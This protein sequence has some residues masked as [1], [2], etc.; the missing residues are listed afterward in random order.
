MKKLLTIILTLCMCLSL[1]MAL[2]AC[3]LG[4]EEPEHTHTYENVWSYDDTYHWYACG[5]E[6]CSSTSQKAEHNI[7]SDTCSI[8]GYEQTDPTPPP[9]QSANK[10]TEEEFYAAFAFEDVVSVTIQSESNTNI[11][12]GVQQGVHYA[13][14]FLDGNK[15]KI[16]S[17]DITTY[18]EFYDTYVYIYALDATDNTWVRSTV[19]PENAAGL[20]TLA[21]LEEMLDGADFSD[22]S[23][24]DGYYIGSQIFEEGTAYEYVVNFKFQFENGKLISARGEYEVEGFDC[25]DYMTFT[26]YNSTTVNVPTEYRENEDEPTPPA[27]SSWASYFE[28][29]NV[30]ATKISSTYYA[31]YDMTLTETES[32]KVDGSEWLWETTDYWYG[33]TSHS[34]FVVYFDGLNAYVNGVVDN[35]FDSQSEM[36]FFDLDFSMYESSFDEATSGVYTAN[37]INMY[38]VYSYE[39]VR[40]T[41]VDENISTISYEVSLTV[42]GATYTTQVSCSFSDWNETVVDGEQYTK[43]SVWAS[44]FDFDNVTINETMQYI[45]G[46]TT[47]YGL[48]SEWKVD[49]DAWVCNR[50]MEKVDGIVTR[51]NEVY[52]NGINYYLNGEPVGEEDAYAYH[53]MTGSILGELVGSERLFQVT[54]QGTKTIYTAT[55]IMVFD[56]VMYTDVELVVENG[57]IVKITYVRDN[58]ASFEGQHYAGTFTLEF[59][60]Y[61]VTIVEGS[62]E[63][64]HTCS[65]TEEIPLPKFMKSD[66]TCYDKA[67]YYLSCECGEYREDTFEFGEAL[68]CDWGDWVSSGA[69][70]HA[71]I[72]SRDF[73]HTETEYCSGGTASC[74]RLAICDFCKVGYGEL[75][76]HVYLELKNNENEHWFECSCGAKDKIKI[77]VPSDVATESSDQIC[78][79]CNRVLV[80]ALGHVHALHLEKVEY[81]ES[82][83]IEAGNIEYYICSCNKMFEDEM[84]II[85]I[86]DENDVVLE[87]KAHSYNISK[88]D[89]TQHWYQCVCGDIIGKEK[90]K[91][92]TATCVLKAECS[93]CGEKYGELLSHNFVELKKGED[94]HWYECVCGEKS[95]AEFHKGGSAS[96]TKLAEC[97]ICF[98]SYGELL[99]HYFD[100]IKYNENEHWYE[101]ICGKKNEQE[102][103][104]GGVATCTEFAV[105]SVCEIEYGE[106]SEHKGGSATCKTKA[107]CVECEMEYGEFGE[108]EFNQEIIEEEYRLSDAT[109]THAAWYFYA[110]LCGEKGDEFFVY[111]EALG[112]DYI[113]LRFDSSQHWYECRCGLRTGTEKHKG[114]SVDC[115][116]LPICSVC[117]QQ[118]GSLISHSWNNGCCTTCGTE[119]YSE[120]L[121]FTLNDD[122]KSYSVTGVTSTSGSGIGGDVIILES[123]VIV[124]TPDLPIV[125]GNVFVSAVIPSIYKGLPVTRIEENAFEGCGNLVNVSIGNNVVEIG[126]YAFW[127]CSKLETINIPNGILTIGSQAFSG[128]D[129]LMYNEID[130]LYYLGNISN[131]CVYLIKVAN[132]IMTSVNVDERCKLIRGG[133]LSG[134]NI[135]DLRLP[136]VGESVTGS[137]KTH[138]G[139]IFGATTYDYNSTKI[140]A[141]L[142]TV[143]VL[144]NRIGD[145]AFYNASD[146]TTVVLSTD[147]DS[148]G[149]YSF[150]GCCSLEEIYLGD[151][152]SSVGAYAFKNCLKLSTIAVP[153]TVEIIGYAAFEGC[154]SLTYIKLP[155][156]GGKESDSSNNHFGYIFGAHQFL[157][158]VNYV[159]DSLM[160]ISIDRGMISAQAFNGCANLKTVEIGPDVSEIGLNAFSGCSGISE[161]YVEDLTRWCSIVGLE[162]LM[163]QGQAKN[164]FVKDILLVNLILPYDVLEIQPFAFANCKSIESVDLGSRVETIWYSVFKGSNNIKTMTLPFVGKSATDPYYNYFGY[165]FGASNC[166]DNYKHIPSGLKTVVVYG[167]GVG[168][169]AFLD[170]SYLTT[171]KLLNHVTYVGPSAFKGCDNLEK[172]TVPFVGYKLNMES[173][174]HFG[175]IFGAETYKENE[176]HIPGSLKDVTVLSGKIFDHAFY[177]CNNLI[178]ITLADDV[179]SVGEYSF[180]D[181]RM[182]SNLYVGTGLRTIGNFAFY[183][184]ESLINICIKDIEAWC[185]ISD[186]DGLMIYGGS[187]KM[188]YMFNSSTFEYE[189][190]T[191]LIIPEDAEDVTIPS[192]AFYRCKNLVNVD[193]GNSI[194]YIG[195]SVFT[196][197]SSIKSMV[198]PFV[199]S[200]KFNPEYTNIGYLFGNDRYDGQNYM[201]PT[202]LTDITVLAGKISDYAFYEVTNITDIHFGDEVDSIGDYAFYGCIGLTDL[203]L[204][205]IGGVGQFAFA[206]CVGLEYLNLKV[207]VVDGYAFEDCVGLKYLDLNVKKVYKYVFKGCENLSEVWMG[208]NLEEINE[209]AFYNCKKIKQLIIPSNVSISFGAFEGCDSLE[210]IYLPFTFKTVSF[211]ENMGNLGYIFGN[212]G[213]SEQND[214]IPAGLKKVV[215]CSSQVRDYA[216][217]GCLN[218]ESLDLSCVTS[219]GDRAMENCAE[220]KEVLLSSDLTYVGQR[221]FVNCPSLI[222]YE[223]NGLKYLG[224]EYRKY[225]YL[226][227]VI[228]NEATNYVIEDM[229]RVIGSQ[230]FLNCDELLDVT[231]GQSIV[232]I[233]DSA[234]NSCDELKTVTIDSSV[235]HVGDYA[236]YNCNKLE[237]VVIGDNVDQIGQYAFGNC[238]ILSE[239]HFNDADG[240][241]RKDSSSASSGINTILSN[242]LKNAEYFRD[243]YSDKYWAKK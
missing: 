104:K 208:P 150:Y 40:I 167:G 200:S 36:F 42:G 105:C 25:Y 154:N 159:P 156:I 194:R 110:C 87:I 59:S 198:L 149:K 147:V 77:H 98:E 188:M 224:N 31:D 145:Y 52:Y 219:I 78:I 35:E 45:V 82:T 55:N 111:G 116:K 212:A 121:I 2:T 106:Y 15:I 22:F 158:N 80:P 195:T 14:T 20:V 24:E 28:F 73:T 165:V 236:F 176:K 217:Y 133:A 143:E 155:F 7:V 13:T 108:H 130:G 223:K 161:I 113:N 204:V 128:C 93:V 243:T 114:G 179:A 146:L 10:V 101:C 115:E 102:T 203:D 46:G 58:A 72:C 67:I 241:Q 231:I 68:G 32:I 201:I 206:R 118:Y 74:E 207:T 164:L 8:C 197:C 132:H 199:G 33:G 222:Y 70:Q 62:T 160:S 122:G 185:K 5:D 227:S 86:M 119:E 88:N 193:L 216:F 44:Y 187:Y 210:E 126:D 221:A 180:Y 61:D 34:V 214:Y 177:K 230:C 65:Y 71:H 123:R 75:K 43:P 139:W 240:W 51:V 17:N 131:P 49:G 53:Y 171:I 84:G 137:G 234:F 213:W 142:K 184:C 141:S 229:C 152:L 85:E 166:D 30:T 181:C 162:Y 99:K 182:L 191:D 226:D 168:S 192:Y 228:S 151:T 90:H 3:N 6:T 242:D 178:H 16:I 233:G 107:V 37:E 21:S 79:E 238:Y 148:I 109:C 63:P 169:E 64:S 189:P 174:S 186:H 170:C 183:E 57:K 56:V 190:L 96:C 211:A 9:A 91:G 48:D 220:L 125:G 39:N 23:F 94:I 196:G 140:P 92:G 218:I 19:D 103:H 232:H 50:V 1:G 144:C 60:D 27:T 26:D 95:N 81:S 129:S 38:G 205:G 202:C 18:A 153:K 173:D 76:E 138:L 117:T 157:T 237:S 175:Y 239:I 163:Y 215:V 97:S 83:C 225:I 136:F 89:S 66:A 235:K 120:E 54:N 209:Y 47:H 69:D 11:V 41:I 172:L 12:N 29:E 112:H 124:I 134:S 135:T 100:Y 4:S 127:R